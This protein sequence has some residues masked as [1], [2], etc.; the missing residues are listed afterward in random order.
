MMCLIQLSFNKLRVSQVP[1]MKSFEKSDLIVMAVSETAP[2]SLSPIPYSLSPSLYSLLPIPQS[3]HPRYYPLLPIPYPIHS[4][5]GIGSRE[6]FQTLV[7]A[8]FLYVIAV[9]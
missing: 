5:S 9:P 6:Q 1:S 8:P 3:L 7:S 2:H 4:E